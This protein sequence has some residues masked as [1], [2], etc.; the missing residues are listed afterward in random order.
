[1]N[2]FSNLE[3]LKRRWQTFDNA[4]TPNVDTPSVFALSTASSHRKSIVRT[5]RTSLIVCCVSVAL[6]P[7]SLLKVLHVPLFMAYLCAVYFLIMG[8][9]SAVGLD[10]VSRI[11]LAGMPTLEILR[12]VKRFQTY[13]VWSKVAGITM[14]VPLLGYMLYVFGNESIELLVSGMG[15][16]LVGLAIGLSRDRKVVRHIRS[17]NDE[18]KELSAGEDL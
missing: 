13:R 15:G 1:M 4:D 18:L 11:D 12:K 6:I 7:C 9:L 14:A 5:Y 8:V 2:D 3:E 17:I 16:A 10:I